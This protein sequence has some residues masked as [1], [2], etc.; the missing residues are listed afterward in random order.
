MT[1]DK[2]NNLWNL[3][4]KFG[5]KNIWGE[6]L[7]FQLETCE[8]LDTIGLLLLVINLI[9]M[10]YSVNF[11]NSQFLGFTKYLLKHLTYKKSRYR[12][13]C[14]SST[15]NSSLTL[16]NFV[17]W[18]QYCSEWCQDFTTLLTKISLSQEISYCISMVIMMMLSRRGGGYNQ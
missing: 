13:H 11:A 12:M 14:K 2:I 8:L 4:M 5:N 15:L 16:L 7:I 1:D 17:N 10:T 6:N 18:I 9:P 3:L